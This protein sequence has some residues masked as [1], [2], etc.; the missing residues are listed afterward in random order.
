MDAII[1]PPGEQ[2][3]E[4]ADT[5]APRH[6]H[7]RAFD[8]LT[9]IASYVCDAPIAAIVLDDGGR[10]RLA[11]MHGLSVAHDSMLSFCAA[12][13]A[14]F[15]EIYDTLA[16]DR[17]RGHVLVAQPPCIR[18]CTKVELKTAAGYGIGSLLVM[19]RAPRRFTP[20]MKLVLRQLGVIAAQLIE[21]H[22][23]NSWNRTLMPKPGVSIR[24]PAS[25]I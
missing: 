15:D 23:A 9:R 21:A 1:T 19:D 3:G 20:T 8:A 24:S 11:S 2:T 4:S 18:G 14:D 12:I 10:L 5:R 16:S 13:S 7:E 6:A 22:G 25:P 17:L